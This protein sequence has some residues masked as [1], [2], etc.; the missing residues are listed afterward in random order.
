MLYELGESEVLKINILDDSNLQQYTIE[1]KVSK[2]ITSEQFLEYI[3]KEKILKENYFNINNDDWSILEFA[4]QNNPCQTFSIMDMTN[5]KCQYK[6]LIS[7]NCSL[8]KALKY[9]N[10]PNYEVNLLFQPGGIGAMYD[11]FFG[12]T[13]FTHANEEN[14][15]YVPHI[16][17]KYQ[18]REA[19]YSLLNFKKITGAKYP[20]KI[21][22]IISNKLKKENQVLKDFWLHTTNGVWPKKYPSIEIDV[23]R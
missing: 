1:L 8:F 3:L 21:D 16:H 23:L 10:I 15:K 19:S 12:I 11:D 2:L 9:L 6:K 5:N 17:T 4:K 7:G 13:F 18:N 22:K 14:H 20:A